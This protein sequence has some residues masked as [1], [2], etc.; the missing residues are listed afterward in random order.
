MG[1]ERDLSATITFLLHL[2]VGLGMDN[3]VW[4]PT[5]FTKKSDRLHEGDIALAFIA[6]ILDKPRSPASFG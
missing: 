5:V 4:V 6:R 1:V 3:A 2:F